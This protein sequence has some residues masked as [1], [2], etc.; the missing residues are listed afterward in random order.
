M[1]IGI[2]LISV[3][4][5]AQISIRVIDQTS[6]SP[7]Q[8]V[9]ILVEN[10]NISF[11]SDA[12]GM[13]SLSS[14]SLRQNL[15]FTHVSYDTLRISGKSLLSK[16][17]VAL[18]PRLY[19]LN[20]FSLNSENVETVFHSNYHYVHDYEIIENKLV[21]IT[22]NRSLKKDAAITFCTLDQEILFEFKI[23]EEPIELI[24][25]YKDELFLKTKLSLFRLPILGDS[26]GFEKVNAKDYQFRIN[27][28]VDSVSNHV[29]FNDYLAYLPRMNYFA[30]DT[31]D[32]GFF[33]FKY[34]E[35][36]VV[37]KMH[38]WEY[39]E[40]PLEEKRRARELSEFIPNMDKKD[41]AAM[42]TG[43]HKTMYYEPVSAPL[44][45]FSDSLF[46]FDHS[47]SML[48]KFKNFQ[49]IDSVEITYHK[50]ER[51]FRW[52]DEVLFDEA[53]LDFYAVFLK[54]GYYYLKEICTKM[55]GVIS[56]F[57]VEKQFVENLK[58][59]NGYAYYLYKKTSSPEKPFLYRELLSQ[60]Q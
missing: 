29:V 26:I 48:Y 15:I 22:F 3:Q 42:F 59:Q 37:N 56:E 53:S 47:N 25:D 39:Y 30:F 57:K 44:F 35:N 12:Q 6:V 54:N 27:N 4:L 60:S 20:T 9:H 13:V 41:V 8:G 52:K 16:Y 38:R 45:V 33:K 23:G 2:V 43:F 17:S 18:K 58:V 14:W 55:G 5:R 49:I 19:E 50:S 1:A 24:K 32:S 28:C 31:R 46:I 40:L 34:I 10:S 21:L 7:I 11:V 51:F 36:E